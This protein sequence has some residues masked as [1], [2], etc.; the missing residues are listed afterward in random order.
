MIPG[1]PFVEFRCRLGVSQDS[2]SCSEKEIEKSCP[3]LLT[4]EPAPGSIFLMR[5]EIVKSLQR[6]K[7]KE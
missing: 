5:Q 3:T 6:K 4:T 2:K 7:L 1:N